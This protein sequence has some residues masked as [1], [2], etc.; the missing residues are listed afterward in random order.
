VA[1]VSEGKK[2]KTREKTEKEEGDEEGR[3]N[4]K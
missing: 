3:E 4:L 2:N 1:C